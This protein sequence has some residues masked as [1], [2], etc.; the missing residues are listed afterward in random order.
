[1]Y[2][3]PWLPISYSTSSVVAFAIAEASIIANTIVAIAPRGAKERQKEE[4]RM[5]KET[6]SLFYMSGYII[7]VTLCDAQCHTER[8]KISNL[9]T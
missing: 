2:F 9:Q 4:P 5:W 6:I 1:V 3:E 8:E 7:K